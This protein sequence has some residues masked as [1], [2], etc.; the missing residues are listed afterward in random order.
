MVSQ[1]QWESKDD[2]RLLRGMLRSGAQEAWGVPWGE[3]VQGRSSQQCKRRWNL[4]LKRVPDWVNKSFTES[5]QLLVET[6]YPKLLRK[7][8]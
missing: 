2:R 6:H 1:G 3:L 4:M 8:A 5:L 7:D